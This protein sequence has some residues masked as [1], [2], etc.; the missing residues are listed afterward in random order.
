MATMI[1]PNYGSMRKVAQPEHSLGEKIHRGSFSRID[2]VLPDGT[3]VAREWLKC[4][5]Y[6]HDDSHGINRMLFCHAKDRSYQVAA[7]INCIEDKLGIESS[8]VGPTQR[9]TIS[10]L[11]VSTWWTNSS[12]RRSLFTI[13]LRAGQR[14]RPED[15]NF[16]EALCSE[17]YARL[18]Y[19]AVD[20]FLRGHTKYTGR[21]KGWFTQFRYGEGNWERPL[22]P[23]NSEIRRLLVRP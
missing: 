23:S 20:W 21:M 11:N 8:E 16:E 4:R 18:T 1:A 7:F 12:M 10:W 22:P 17:P 15:H 14:Y 19:P 2:R 5:E 3:F 6:F 9:N 13:L